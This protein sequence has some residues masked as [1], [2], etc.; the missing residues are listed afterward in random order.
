MSGDTIGLISLGIMVIINIIMVSFY[1]GKVN[2]MVRNQKETF[3]A[4]CEDNAKHFGHLEERI[5]TKCSK[6][7]VEAVT[8]RVGRLE[9]MQMDSK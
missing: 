3:L 6:E 9:V 7:V 4:H 2:E 5:E 8:D 1:F